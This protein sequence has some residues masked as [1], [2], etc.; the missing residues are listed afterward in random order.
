MSLGRA[1][2]RGAGGKSGSRRVR[3]EEDGSSLGEEQPYGSLLQLL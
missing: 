1:R 2:V 3:V